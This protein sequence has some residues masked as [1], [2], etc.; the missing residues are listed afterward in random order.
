[1]GVVSCAQDE[2]IHHTPIRYTPPPSVV[3]IDKVPKAAMDHESRGV[4]IASL[5]L[6]LE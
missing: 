4:D 2:H 6:L 5:K 3:L 1:M